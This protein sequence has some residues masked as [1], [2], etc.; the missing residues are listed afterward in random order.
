MTKTRIT[1]KSPKGIEL[2]KNAI[3]DLTIKTGFKIEENA[4][5]SAPVDT[6]YYRSQIN[7]D[8]SNNVIASAQYSA[9][10]EY[11]VPEHEIKPVFAQ[12]LHFVKDG[13]DVFAKRALIPARRPN[14][15]MR[16]AAAQTQKEI[17][18]IWK[19]ALRDNGL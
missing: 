2:L 16:N 3:Q 8:G 19:E 6:G 15:V 4:K 12:A 1:I 9:A 10:I 18:Q 17:P 14:P 11:G 13:N 7:Y 5:E